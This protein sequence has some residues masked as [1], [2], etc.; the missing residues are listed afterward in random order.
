ML[1][2]CGNL[3]GYVRKTSKGFKG[4]NGSHGYG[5]RNSEHT[6]V[7][8][9]CT[10]VDLVITNTYFT[11]CGSQ[12]LTYHSRN[13][14]SQ[15]DYI[16]VPKSDF[17]S[18]RDVKVI[19]SEECVSQHKLLVRDLE[20]NTTFSK[21]VAHYQNENY[22]SCQKDPDVRLWFQN[23]DRESAHFFEY[24]QNSDSVWNKIKTCLLDTS[25]TTCGWTR[26]GNPRL[27]ETWW[28]NDVMD[29]TIKEK[30]SGMSGRKV[31]IKKY[32]QA[33]RKGKSAV[34]TARKTV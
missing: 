30:N 4:I 8:K 15:I 9:F 25:D 32:L 3:N 28:W 20:L 27:K 1:L 16:L 29:C 22:R 23:S 13:A 5:I 34:Y 10:A 18:V 31:D 19:G 17:K 33:K 11:K 24:L 6:R 26:G 2:E 7:L 14:C 21:Y 12:L